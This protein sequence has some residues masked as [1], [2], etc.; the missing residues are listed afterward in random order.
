MKCPKCENF[1]KWSSE[2]SYEDLDVPGNGII[3]VYNCINIDCDVDD[4]YIFTP[5]DAEM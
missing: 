4:V 1:L 3:G 5:I 2:D